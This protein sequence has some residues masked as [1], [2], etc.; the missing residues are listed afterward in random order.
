GRPRRP[1]DA[2]RRPGR[3]ARP[4]RRRAPDRRGDRARPPRH[5]APPDHAARAPRRAAR[6]RRGADALRARRPARAVEHAEPQGAREVE[7]RRVST[8]RARAMGLMDGKVAVVLGVANKR[9]IAWAI[10]RALADAGA[11]L[12]LNYQNERMRDG[13]E[14]LA[15]ELGSKAW[16]APCDVTEEG[17]VDAFFAGV[18]AE[19]GGCD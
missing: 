3:G 8:Y 13:V 2:A 19:F 10:A 4:T 9:S 1:P 17:A 18:E 14:K 16:L 6:R 15:E 5:H 7:R 11:R 12:A